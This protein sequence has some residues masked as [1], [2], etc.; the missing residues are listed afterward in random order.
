MAEQLTEF[1]IV[2]PPA[3]NTNPELNAAR[4]RILTADDADEAD[5]QI[6]V[7]TLAVLHS[8][9]RILMYTLV[10]VPVAL[11]A[12]AVVIALVMTSSS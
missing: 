9:R 3:F 10:V 7:E 8:I 4:F 11:V 5:L 1:G 6:K 12:V 2:A